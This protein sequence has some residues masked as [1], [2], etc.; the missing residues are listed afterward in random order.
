MVGKV[1]VSIPP[2]PTTMAMYCLP[3]TLYE[4]GQELGTSFMRTSHSSLP[5]VSS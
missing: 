2:L 3:L 5:E 4:M 1:W